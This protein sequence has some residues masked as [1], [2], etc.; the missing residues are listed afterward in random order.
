MK[1]LASSDFHGKLPEIK[2]PFDLFLIAGDV[3]PVECHGKKF[4]EEWLLNDFVKWINSLPFNTPWSKVVMVWGNHDFWGE[5]CG[6]E[7]TLG[8]E[9]MCNNRLKILNHESYN[10]EFPVNDGVDDFKIFGTPYCGMFG[11]WAFMKEDDELDKLFSEI[12]NDTDI[13]VSHDSPNV[14]GLGDITQ[15]Y[16]AKQGTGNRVLFNHIKRVEPRLFVSGHFH[17]GNHDFQKIGSIYMA[18]VS[19]INEA[20][21][22]Y[23]PILLINYDEETRRIINGENL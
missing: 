9:R 16:W 4:Q 20:Y 18:N 11:R 8:L 14:Y 10:F 12:P 2:I 6:K 23:W 3:C 21:D 13:I 1:I 22:P 15:G 17:S 7:N 5:T 19:Y